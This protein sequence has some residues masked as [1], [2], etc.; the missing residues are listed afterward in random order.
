MGELIVEQMS[1]GMLDTNCYML[2]DGGSR[3]GYVIDPGGQAGRIAERAEQLKLK[4][5]G[6][7]CTHGHFDHIGAVGRVSELLDAPVMISRLDSGYLDG[8]M[9]R[10]G[11]KMSSFIARNPSSV[12]RVGGGDEILFGDY[13]ARVLDTPGHTPGSLSF[14]CENNLFCG[15]LLFKGSVGRT[16]LKGSS[17]AA[18]LE[19]IKREVMSLP[20]D[21]RV[22]PGHGPATTVGKERR[23]NPYLGNL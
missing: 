19:S 2:M 23:S 1:V 6:I 10:G 7:L 4:C 12:E 22:W 15:D 21:Y 18:L 5:M 14:L 9:K 16:D 11:I 17:T 8:S 3:D 20:D 13:R